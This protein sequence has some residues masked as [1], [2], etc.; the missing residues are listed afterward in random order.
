LKSFAGNKGIFITTSTF[1]KEA[2]EF[3]KSVSN[4][5]IVLIEG[6]QESNGP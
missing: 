5:K 4:S 2:I 6:G 1:T 3:A